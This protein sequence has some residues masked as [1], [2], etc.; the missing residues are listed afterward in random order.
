MSMAEWLVRPH[1]SEGWQV[2]TPARTQAAVAPT[3]HEAVTKAAGM[4]ADEGGGQLLVAGAEGPP[5]GR[6]RVPPTCR[7]YQRDREL[8][9]PHPH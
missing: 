7:P 8:D 4:I 5:A 1:P 2:L 9:L 3:R 6:Y